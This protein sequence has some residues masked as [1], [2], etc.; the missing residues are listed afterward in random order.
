MRALP[1]AGADRAKRSALGLN[2]A[3]ETAI[4]SSPATK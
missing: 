2:D 3:V 1:D 4:D